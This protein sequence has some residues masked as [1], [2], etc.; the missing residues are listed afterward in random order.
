[1]KTF[2]PTLKSLSGFLI[3][4]FALTLLNSACKKKTD[5][6]VDQPK[7]LNKAFLYDKYWYNQGNTISHKFNANGT[8]STIG[9]WKWLN[10]S[11]SMEVKITGSGSRLVWYFEWSTEHEFSAKPSKNSGYI[12]FKDQKW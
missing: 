6:P 1:M 3:L 12:L 9:T 10:N 8:Y 11:D 7:T 2:Q 5:D 4:G